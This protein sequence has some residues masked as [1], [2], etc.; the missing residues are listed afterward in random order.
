MGTIASIDFLTPGGLC[1]L[2]AALPVCRSKEESACSMKSGVENAT[3]GAQRHK[4]G[5][6]DIVSL[7]RFLPH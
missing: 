5:G 6:V 2:S 7:G 3:V 4:E 1:L